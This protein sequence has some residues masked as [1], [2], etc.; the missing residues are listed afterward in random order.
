MVIE[1]IE[2]QLPGAVMDRHA[3]RGDQT[4]VVDRERFLEV[5]DF[6]FTEGFQLLLD[7][8]AVDLETREPFRRGLPLA[9]PRQPGAAARQG[10]RG[11]RRPPPSLTGPFKT[12]DWSEREVFDMFGIRFE[13]HPD[14]RR[15]LIWPDFPGHPLR[16]DFPLDGGDVFCT[17]DMAPPRPRQPRDLNALR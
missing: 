11:R 7:V 15:L 6:I 12:A 2:A 14:L 1:R 17:Q 3:F 10:A 9:E 4:I 13:G 5:V 8:T 16:K